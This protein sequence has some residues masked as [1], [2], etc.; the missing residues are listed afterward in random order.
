MRQS[1]ET[2]NLNFISFLCCCHQVCPA[3]DNCENQ[4]FSKRLYAETE[5]VKTDERGWG[6]RTNQALKK[7]GVELNVQSPKTTST[8]H[9]FSICV[10]FQLKCEQTKS[11]ITSS[12]YIQSLKFLFVLF[13]PGRLRDR[14]CGRGDRLRGVPAANQTRP[15][16]SCDKLLHAH[17][18][19]GNISLT[20]I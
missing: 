8:C 13:S 2:T 12:L 15:W 16:K 1:G 4:C 20:L 10:Y 14:V 9:C 17:P 19:E 7:V 6:L 11:W 5:V 18:H 3:G